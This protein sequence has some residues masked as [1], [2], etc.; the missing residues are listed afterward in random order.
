MRAPDP[1]RVIVL[2]VIFD[3][4]VMYEREFFGKSAEMVCFP[5]ADLELRSNITNSPFQDSKLVAFFLSIMETE[6]GKDESCPEVLAVL[7]IGF[8]KFLLLGIVDDP[9]VCGVPPAQETPYDY[10]FL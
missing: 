9:K 1:I 6:L 8:S 10:T 3:L 7:C 5:F 2:R 4:I